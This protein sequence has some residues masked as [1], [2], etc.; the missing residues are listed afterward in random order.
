MAASAVLGIYILIFFF[1]TQVMAVVQ[2]DLLQIA[3][4]FVAFNLLHGVRVIAAWM[5]GWASAVILLPAA[6]FVYLVHTLQGTTFGFEF[7]LLSLVFLTSAPLAFTILHLAVPDRPRSS[8]YEWRLVVLAGIVSAF[9]NSLAFGLLRPPY[10][11]DG[12]PLA[13]LAG[14]MLSQGL[15]LVLFLMLAMAV[16][17]WFEAAS[18]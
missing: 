7:H 15:G 2:R 4:P 11:A 3:L 14:H 5:F 1:Q 17:R 9:L 6:G 13:W 10:P 8:R 12:S 18:R 16:M